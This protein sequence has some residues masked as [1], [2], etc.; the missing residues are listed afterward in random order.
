MKIG[1]FFFIEINLSVI[2]ID[3]FI[4]VVFIKLQL[5]ILI[6]LDDYIQCLFYLCLFVYRIECFLCFIS[7][8]YK[9]NLQYV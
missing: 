2:N 6:V 5:L 3:C 9:F 7:C 8:Y 4:E 1:W